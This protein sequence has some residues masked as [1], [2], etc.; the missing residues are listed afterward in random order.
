MGASSD[1]DEGAEAWS[2]IRVEG[3]EG[4]SSLA[5]FFAQLIDVRSYG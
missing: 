1:L 4:Y 2:F 3:P 5:I